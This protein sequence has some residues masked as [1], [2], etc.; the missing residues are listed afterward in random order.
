MGNVV[1]GLRALMPVLLEMGPAAGLDLHVG[2][3]RVLNYSSASTFAM[4]RALEDVPMASSF[5]IAGHGVYLG[6]PLGPESIGEEFDA[7]ILKYQGR[8]LHIRAV[9]G[10]TCERLRAH[11]VFAASV[12]LFLA[13]L[14]ELPRRAGAIEAATVASLLASPMHAITAHS[15]S[16]CLAHSRRNKFVP[17]VT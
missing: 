13:H 3:T 8:C 9:A 6:V 10:H 14:V 4:R 1:R 16:A 5:I 15:L 11:Q 17:V 2:K 7:A 12:L